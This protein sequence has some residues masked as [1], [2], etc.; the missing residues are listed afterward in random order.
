MSVEPQDD[1]GDDE[2]G[3]LAALRALE[4]LDTA[5]EQELDEL[6]RLASYIA[7]APMSALSLVDAER[8]WF[9][10]RVGLDMPETAR[11]ASFCATAIQ[12][13]DEVTIVSDAAEDP[14]FRD[15]GFVKDDPN[16]RF[17]CGIPLQVDDGRAVGTVCVFDTVPRELDDEQI[18][19]LRLVAREVQQKLQRRAQIKRA[20]AAAREATQ[21]LGESERRFSLLVANVKD[22]AIF[23]LDP[24]G[25]IASWNGGAERTFGYAEDEVLGRHFG[26]FYPPE[27]L[28][29]GKPSEELRL[30]T[31]TGTYEEE[32]VRLRRDGTPFWV[33]TTLSPVRDEDGLL[34]GFAKVTRDI[35]ERRDANEKLQGAFKEAIVRLSA[36]AEFRDEDTG[37]HIERVGRYAELLA[38]HI[39][40]PEDRCVLIR[41]AAPLH[42]VGKIGIP[43]AILLKPGKLTADEFETM[44]DHASI[45]EK[46]LANSA[47]ELLDFAA[48]IAASH[49][50]KWDGSG[51]P[52]GLAGHAIPI[53]GRIVAVADVFDALTSARPYKSAMPIGEAIQILRDARGAHFDPD[54]LDA[55]L[56]LSDQ[57]A[58]VRVELE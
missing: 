28:R 56:E 55:F 29:L 31:S 9:K 58:A 27:D 51:Y 42:D 18:A 12:R 1:S 35:T 23:L 40:L 10:S 52:R 53:E 57:M 26:L 6:I 21:E 14:R 49:H 22:Y 19:A 54:V 11:E 17:Y 34:Q 15:Q 36:A 50:E 33:T 37:K 13:P 20:A 44:K 4:L 30:A 8:L 2:A 24:E 48:S 7:K 45:G 5:P 38:R 43:D 41:L 3:R 16:L 47:S 32:G 25:N 39:G 46:L